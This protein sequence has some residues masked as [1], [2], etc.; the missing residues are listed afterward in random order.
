MFRVLKDC[1]AD[2][3]MITTS[4]T[5]ISLLLDSATSEQCIAALKKAFEL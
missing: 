2:I 5:D 3:L 1:E 4:A